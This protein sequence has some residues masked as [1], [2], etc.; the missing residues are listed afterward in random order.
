MQVIIYLAFARRLLPSVPPLLLHRH[1]GTS[2]AWGKQTKDHWEHCGQ[3]ERARRSSCHRGAFKVSASAERWDALNKGCR[4]NPAQVRFRGPVL[5]G[6]ADVSECHLPA[7]GVWPR[8][9]NIRLGPRRLTISETGHAGFIAVLTPHAGALCAAPVHCKAS[10][11]ATTHAPRAGRL[12][13]MGSV[14]ASR[15]PLALS[16]A[17]SA[18]GGRG[19]MLASYNGGGMLSRATRKEEN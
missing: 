10:H 7:D 19:E 18:K 9:P 3:R 16:E 5:Y 11:A 17:C 6:F 15:R 12:W 14:P 8:R 4:C 1:R 13:L 2:V